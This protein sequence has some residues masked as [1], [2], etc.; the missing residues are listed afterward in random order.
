M[1]M[2]KQKEK[3]VRFSSEEISQMAKQKKWQ[4]NWEKADSITEEELEEMVKNDPDD[5]YLE[6]EDFG[7]GTL[8]RNGEWA[9]Q[10]E[11]PKKKKQ[12]TLRL[13]ED[14]LEYFRDTGRGYQTRINNVLKAFVRA[15]QESRS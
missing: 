2:K 13:D 4:S 5:V 15:Q 1:T 8:Y 12:I 9:R 7:K 14:V 3:I 11:E 10:F 6:D